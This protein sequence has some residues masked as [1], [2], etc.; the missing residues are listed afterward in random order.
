MTSKMVNYSS[1]DSPY[2]SDEKHGDEYSHSR[3]FEKFEGINKKL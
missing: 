3:H 2:R 1:R